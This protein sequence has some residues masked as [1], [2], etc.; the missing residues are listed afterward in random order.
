MK[1]PQHIGNI[2]SEVIYFSYIGMNILYLLG[3]GGEYIVICHV[4]KVFLF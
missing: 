2:M 1:I 3:E 4:V